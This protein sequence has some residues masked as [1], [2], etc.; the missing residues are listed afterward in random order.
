MARNIHEKRVNLRL[1][2]IHSVSRR[3]V[4]RPAIANANGIVH[5]TK[6]T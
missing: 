5:P 3:P 1:A 6:P 2:T 4:A